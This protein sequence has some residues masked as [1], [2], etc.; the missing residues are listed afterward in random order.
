MDVGP[1]FYEESKSLAI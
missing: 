1:S